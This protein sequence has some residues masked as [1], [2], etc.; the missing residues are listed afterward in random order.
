MTDLPL[1]ITRLAERLAA[2]QGISVEEAIK[3]AI[4]ASATAAGLA[5]DTQHPRRR[6]TVDE[7]LAVG[8]EIAALPVLDPRPATQIMD[9]I[10]AP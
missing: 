4:E 1:E 6:M 10:N 7:M 8:A 5:G 3:R 9:D 2:A